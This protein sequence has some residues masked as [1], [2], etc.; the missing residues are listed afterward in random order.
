MRFLR[1]CRYIMYINLFSI[2]ISFYRFR[3]KVRAKQMILLRWEIRDSAQTF[4]SIWHHQIAELA[5][6]ILSNGSVSNL[7]ETCQVDKH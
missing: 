7:C 6:T 3:S 2:S 5:G 1:D 4:E